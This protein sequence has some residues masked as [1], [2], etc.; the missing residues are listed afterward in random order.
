MVLA[1]AP[2]S[3]LIFVAW[4]QLAEKENSYGKNKIVNINV[5]KLYMYVA[6]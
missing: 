4:R 1:P 3:V 5:A 6:L 2:L